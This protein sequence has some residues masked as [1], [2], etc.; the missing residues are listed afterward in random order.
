MPTHVCRGS[1]YT[2]LLEIK[3]LVLQMSNLHKTLKSWTTSSTQKI[4]KREQTAHIL[5]AVEDPRQKT[6]ELNNR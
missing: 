6:I 4:M 3:L 2:K 5:L 1:V